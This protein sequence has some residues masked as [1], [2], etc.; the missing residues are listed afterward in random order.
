VRRGS[1]SLAVAAADAGGDSNPSRCL[2]SSAEETDP[3]E[4]HRRESPAVTGTARAVPIRSRRWVVFV[5]ASAMAILAVA[6]SS[7][8]DSGGSRSSSK[9]SIPSTTSKLN[10]DQRAVLDAYTQFLAAVDKAYTTPVNPAEPSL[11]A[12]ATPQVAA[13]VGLEVK[14]FQELGQARRG[15]TKFIP[16]EV[17]LAGSQATVSG[18]TVDRTVRYEVSS[19]KVINDRVGRFATTAQ[20]ERGDDG[21]WRVSS[22]ERKGNN[23][24]S[25]D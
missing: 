13:S 4:R 21:A 9:T 12:H 6:C 11:S 5:A 17:T 15:Q 2:S 1:R 8:G 19:G 22:D 18:C 20:L 23:T 25:A 7:S 14:G 10:G 3:C 24:C 16:A